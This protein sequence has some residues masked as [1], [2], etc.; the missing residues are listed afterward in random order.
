MLMMVCMKSIKDAKKQVLVTCFSSN[1]SRIKSILDIAFKTD[2][3]ILVVGRALLRA[4]DAAKEV[5]YLKF[6]RS[7]LILKIFN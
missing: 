2:R 1:I 6:T 7:L 4:I 3:S 5:G